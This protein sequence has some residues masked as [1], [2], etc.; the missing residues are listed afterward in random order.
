M[1]CALAIGL[2][3]AALVLAGCGSSSPA[4]RLPGLTAAKLVRIETLARNFAK[5][6]QDANPSSATVF[7]TR[8]HAA[9]IALGGSAGIL[10][11]IPVYLV[12][13]HGSFVCKYC[14]GYTP[15]GPAHVLTIMLDREKLNSLSGGG[16]GGRVDTRR[17]GPSLRLPLG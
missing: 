12:V 4:A 1:R 9:N 17:I 7:A 10:K 6:E 15:P 16:L 2:A 5:S 11:D 8:R 13:V 14:D 3:G